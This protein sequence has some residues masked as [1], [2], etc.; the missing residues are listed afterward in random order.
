MENAVD[1]QVPLRVKLSCGPDWANLRP[2]SGHSGAQVQLL[3]GCKDS[4]VICESNI[5]MRPDASVAHMGPLA[6][7]STI[8]RGSNDLHCIKRMIFSEST[9]S[10][11]RSPAC[12]DLK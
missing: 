9:S 11:Q 4:P 1:L 10:S 12:N 5:H 8:I 2:Y 6:G 3:E 7:A